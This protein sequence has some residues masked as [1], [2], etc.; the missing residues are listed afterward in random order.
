MPFNK[1]NFVS[2]KKFPQKDRILKSKNKTKQNKKTKQK[3]A[4]FPPPCA[5]TSWPSSAP[6]EKKKKNL[7]KFTQTNKK[8]RMKP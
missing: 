4:F 3:C 7:K 1:T 8:K 2:F 6:F 5:Q